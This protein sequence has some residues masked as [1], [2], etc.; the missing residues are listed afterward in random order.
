MIAQVTLYVFFEGPFWVG[1][2]E[3]A[4]SSE[5]VFSRIVFGAEPTD[6]QVWDCLLKRWQ[7]LA[8]SPATDSTVRD[9]AT[10]PKRRQRQ[11]GRQISRAPVGTRAQQALKAQRELSATERHE[12]ARVRRQEEKDLRFR[13]KQAKRKE[14]HKGH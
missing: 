6:A 5:T 1:L 7:A 9:L 2:V 10:N 13:R 12:A 11:I 14:K 3:R 4:G 8:Y